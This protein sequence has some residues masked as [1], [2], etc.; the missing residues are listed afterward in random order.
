MGGLSMDANSTGSYNVGIGQNALGANTTASY[1]TA[2][3]F[4]AGDS[5][6]TAG[7]NT[8]FG[9]YSLSDLTT[10]GSNTAIGYNT[11][12]YAV[13]SA[14]NIIIGHGCVGVNSGDDDYV[15]TMGIGTGSDRIY[16]LPDSNATWTRVSDERL[17]EEIQD[18]ND[19]GLA[20]VNDLRPVTFKWKP[21][22]DIPEDFPDYDPEATER[23]HDE[24]MYGLIAQEVKEALDKTNITDFGGWSEMDEGVQTIGQSM[25]V[26]P[27]IKAVQELSAKVEELEDKLNNKE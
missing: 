2:V 8:A 20:F 24:K 13:D 21:H 22:S 3:G 17:K 12:P 15:I 16:N 26:Y 7:Q 6:T 10:G 5:I 23:K 11:Q 4:S 18:N 19:C 9:A 14:A 27:L 25:F 1:N